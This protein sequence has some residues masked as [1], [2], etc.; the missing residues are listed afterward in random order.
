V[1]ER[2]LRCQPLADKV[3]D[4]LNVRQVVQERSNALILIDFL[5]MHPANDDWHTARD[6]WHTL[7]N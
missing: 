3:L 5:D 7:N 2:T 6:D 4:C 1:P